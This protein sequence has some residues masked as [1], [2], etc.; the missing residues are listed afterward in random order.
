MFSPRA[1]KPRRSRRNSNEAKVVAV[2]LSG[3]FNGSRLQ[4]SIS[5]EPAPASS[6]SA[7]SSKFPSIWVQLVAL[8]SN[9]QPLPDLTSTSGASA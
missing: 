8:R 9:A 3:S 5:L 2:L 6:A 1:K 7:L 4:M